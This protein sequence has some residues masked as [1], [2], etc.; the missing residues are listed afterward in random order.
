MGGTV[1]YYPTMPRQFLFT[2]VDINE[3]AG[4][5]FS[6]RVLRAQLAAVDVLRNKVADN[7]W[8]AI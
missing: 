1:T 4:S 6:D 8:H 2:L 3:A 5:Y 7:M